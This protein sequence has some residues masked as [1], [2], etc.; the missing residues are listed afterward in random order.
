MVNSSYIFTMIS[1]GNFFF[2]LTVLGQP[3]VP[4]ANL[5]LKYPSIFSHTVHGHI[6]PV[7][8]CQ[9]CFNSTI[10]ADL[11]T[12]KGCLHVA[13]VC[14]LWVPDK[15]EHSPIYFTGKMCFFLFELLFFFAYFIHS[16]SMAVFIY[17]YY[18]CWFEKSL[19]RR[20]AH[21]SGISV[22]ADDPLWSDM[23]KNG[24]IL[25]SSIIF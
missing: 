13:L 8:H 16:F 9:G 12:G 7:S 21:L 5:S 24:D 25:P 14:V 2:K 4:T 20:L 17:Y 3:L 11:V 1:L 15:G 22:I 18:F 10:I 23:K 6:T 19:I